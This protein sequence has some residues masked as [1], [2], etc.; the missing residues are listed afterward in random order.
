[1]NIG[2]SSPGVYEKLIDNSTVA[3]DSPLPGISLLQYGFSKRG[4]DNVI[5][6][7]ESVPSILSKFGTPDPLG[8]K[9]LGYNTTLNWVKGGLTAQYC[10]L[11]AA[12]AANASVYVVLN[13]L[14]PDTSVGA[15]L[16]KAG[17]AYALDSIVY[18]YELTGELTVYTVTEAITKNE[19]G[20]FNESDKFSEIYEW[21]N[22]SYAAGKKVWTYSTLSDKRLI[23]VFEATGNTEDTSNAGQDPIVVITGD[24]VNE[25]SLEANSVGLIEWT[26]IDSIAGFDNITD[27]RFVTDTTQIVDG[28]DFKL[29]R[30]EAIGAGADYNGI[31]MRFSFDEATTYQNSGVPTYSYAV[32]DY[33]ELGEE[34]VMDGESGS[35]TFARNFDS[36]GDSTWV[37]DVLKKYSKIVRYKDLSDS[38]SSLDKLSLTTPAIDNTIYST[39]TSDI[40]NLF[41]KA[42]ISTN[43]LSGKALLSG[44][45][46]GSLFDANGVIDSDVKN[47][48]IIDFYTGLIDENI[49]NNGAVPASFT[50]DFQTNKNVRNTINEFTK[51]SRTDIFVY[52]GGN[53]NVNAEADLIFRKQ[54]FMVDNMRSSL[55]TQFGEYTDPYSGQVIRVPVF[56]TKVTDFANDIDTNGLGANVFGGYNGLGQVTTIDSDTWNYKCSKPYQD[57]FYLASI[58]PPVHESD[59]IYYL[60]T[61]SLQKRNSKLSMN[62][63]VQITQRIQRETAILGRPYIDKFITTKLISDLTA[64]YNEYFT[65]K[66]VPLDAIESVNVNVSVTDYDVKHNQLVV[67]FTIKFNNIL[68]KLI[69]TTVVE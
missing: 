64:D 67:Y 19:E 38:I 20:Y 24:A 58:N 13:A 32:Y 11:T 46:D 22:G 59:G 62:H 61:R 69:L 35:F 10:R 25:P 5:V 8:F 45:N 3:S 34:Y 49:L 63:V 37:Q 2:H 26:L 21:T 50:F 1:M 16:Y 9:D 15:T 30:F 27:L 55:M 43:T 7:V 56:F 66:W 12:D 39:E 28:T 42:E 44:G 17:D 54:E 14:T 65:N 4:E 68:E 23:D 36:S 51:Y 48:L 29:G 53:D 6:N 31:F 60:A 40:Y 57:K 47:Q 41:L 33:N 18:K 52:H